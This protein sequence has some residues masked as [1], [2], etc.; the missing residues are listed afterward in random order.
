[1]KERRIRIFY[2]KGN[3]NNQL[4]HV[5]GTVDGI[6]VYR[7]WS[8]RWRCWRYKVDDFGEIDSLKERGIAKEI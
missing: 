5:R 3:F 2:N 4:L 8:R 1:V 6:T 7:Y